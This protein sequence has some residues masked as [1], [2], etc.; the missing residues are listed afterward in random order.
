MWKLFFCFTAPWF[1]NWRLIFRTHNLFINHENILFKICKVKTYCFLRLNVHSWISL[2]YL[3][4]NCRY[5]LLKEVVCSLSLL[6]LYSIFTNF[7]CFSLQGKHIGRLSHQDPEQNMT[8]FNH[9]SHVL[10]LVLRGL[11]KSGLDFIW[12]FTGISIRQLTKMF[13]L[14]QLS[15]SHQTVIR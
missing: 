2:E 12:K 11:L 8:N 6:S 14:M 9:Q 1:L 10:L 15:G 3:P 5:H 13:T 4:W 7:P